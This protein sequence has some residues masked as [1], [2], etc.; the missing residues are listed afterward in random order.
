M[1]TSIHTTTI[2]MNIFNVSL[3]RIVNDVSQMPCNPTADKK[4]IKK[5]LSKISL[6]SKP[7][8]S[9]AITIAAPTMADHTK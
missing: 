3:P 6:N 7:C 5:R 2:K 4:N 9:L 8:C 1:N